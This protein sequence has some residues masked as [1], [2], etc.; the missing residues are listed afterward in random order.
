MPP[1]PYRPSPFAFSRQRSPRIP[2][3]GGFYHG[4]PLPQQMGRGPG[5]LLA[6]LFNRTPQNIS[7]FHQGFFGGGFGPSFGSGAPSGGIGSGLGK[8][9]NVI[10]N[11]QQAINVVQQVAPIVQQYGPIIK[12]VPT[13]IQM[14]KM[15]QSSD[16]EEDKGDESKEQEVSDEIEEKYESNDH[17]NENSIDDLEEFL[18]GKNSKEKKEYVTQSKPKNLRKNGQSTPKLYI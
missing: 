2:Q 7:H 6:R 14:W 10:G 1:N 11:I 8:V 4:R 18:I 12:N 9:S 13:M 3:T 17:V 15:L 5:G 16:D